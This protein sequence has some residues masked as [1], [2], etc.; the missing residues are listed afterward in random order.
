M[1]WYTGTDRSVIE[2][3]VPLPGSAIDLLETPVAFAGVGS[4]WIG[5][6]G[7]VNGEEGTTAVFL[8]MLGLVSL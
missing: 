4:G 6:A 7:D 8:K 1:A 2:T 5:Y 3:R